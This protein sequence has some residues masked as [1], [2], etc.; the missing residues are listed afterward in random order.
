MMQPPPRNRK[1]AILNDDDKEGE[2]EEPQS[3]PKECEDDAATTK[4]PETSQPN[5]GKEGEVEEPQSAPKECEDDAATTKEPET[6]QPDDDDDKEGEDEEPQSAPKECEDDAATTKEPETSH[7]DDDDDKEGE[8]EEPQS[9]PKECEDDAATTKEPETSHLD[10]D[11]KQEPTA[12]PENSSSDDDKEK[13]ES[14]DVEPQSEPKED[15]SSDDD[16]EKNDGDDVEPQSEPKEDVPVDGAGAPAEESN[17]ESSPEEGQSGGGGG[18]PPRPRLRVQFG[19]PTLKK[20]NRP[21][22]HDDCVMVPSLFGK[23]DDMVNYYRLVEEI[24]KLQQKGVENANWALSRD[25]N[26]MVCE[27]ASMAPTVRKIVSTICKYFHVKEE[28]VLVKVDMFR[29]GGDNKTPEH[30]II[31]YKVQE[32]SEERNIAVHVSFGAEREMTLVNDGDENSAIYIPQRN[33]WAFSVGRD[34]NVRF[35]TGVAKADDSCDDGRVCVRVYGRAKGIVSEEGSPEL[36]ERSD[37]V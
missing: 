16:E 21:L 36:L 3:A 5:D 37:D 12:E 18:G 19:H 34:V 8:D 32:E 30:D 1:Q 23:E 6:S 20:Y 15:S 17:K 26:H 31:A 24:T 2:D 29:D 28:S 35:E 33:N 22:H 14:D 11:D 13:G 4:E 10:D 7:L 9:A 27:N 25:G